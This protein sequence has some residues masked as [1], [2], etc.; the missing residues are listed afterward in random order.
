MK[1]AP[2]K[3]FLM[4]IAREVCNRRHDKGWTQEQLAER[5]DCCRNTISFI[6]QGRNDLSADLLFRL[7]KAFGTDIPGFF[8][9][10]K[11]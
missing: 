5:A 10:A 7:T 9:T 8:G 11:F 6:E 2:N 1:K 4:Q 3:K